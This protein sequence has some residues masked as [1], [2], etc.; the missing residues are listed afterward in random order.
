MWI[1]IFAEQLWNFTMHEVI[2]VY[3]GDFVLENCE[4]GRKHMST[5][6]DKISLVDPGESAIDPVNFASRLPPKTLF[7]R[8]GEHC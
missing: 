1:I 7:M 8:K 6:F 2:S 4:T 5:T 3:S